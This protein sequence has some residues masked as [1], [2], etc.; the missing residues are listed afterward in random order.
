MYGRTL[1]SLPKSLNDH[2]KNAYDINRVREAQHDAFILWIARDVLE[3]YGFGA[4]VRGLDLVAGAV[5]TQTIG[6][7]HARPAQHERGWHQ[8]WVDYRTQQEKER[9]SK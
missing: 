2:S 9:Q 7:M 1:R 5:S 6:P 8:W 4:Y 3:K